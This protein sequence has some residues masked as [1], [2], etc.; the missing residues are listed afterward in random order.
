MQPDYRRHCEIR[1][2]FQ[3]IWRI[4][5]IES[6]VAIQKVLWKRAFFSGD[7]K[8]GMQ[9]VTRDWKRHFSMERGNEQKQWN[10]FRQEI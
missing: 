10:E 8:R 1:T 7:P 3:G 2:K 6:V 9:S 5:S 4:E